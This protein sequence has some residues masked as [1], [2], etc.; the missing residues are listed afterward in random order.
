MHLRSI[1]LMVAACALGGCAVQAS[2]QAQLAETQLIGLSARQLDLCAGLPTKSVKLADGLEIR[3]Y[4]Y[5]PPA[6]DGVNLTLPVVGGGVTLGGGG[7]C[8]AQFE[9]R[10][11]RVDAVRYAGETSVAGAP[12]ARCAPI[13]AHCMLPPPVGPVH[14]AAGPTT[15]ASGPTP[16]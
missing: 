16:S 2:R 4:E 6:T 12:E 11:G 3:T 15:A 13:V 8:N 14:P 1:G 5:T 7:N 10:N 9:L